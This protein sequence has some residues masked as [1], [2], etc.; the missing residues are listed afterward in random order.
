MRII[1]SW[2]GAR[3]RSRTGTANSG[4]RILSPLRLPVPPP[5]LIQEMEARVG[6]ENLRKRQYLR[7]FWVIQMESY[8][9]TYP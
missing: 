9:K 6:I 7:H 3:G 5:G 8:P 2:T 1:R 4:R